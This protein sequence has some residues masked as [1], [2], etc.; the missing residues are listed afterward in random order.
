MF[1]HDKF[2]L[3]IFHCELPPIISYT[4]Q[5]L[6]NQN[7]GH[8][9]NA[10]RLIQY[11]GFQCVMY[12][13]DVLLIFKNIGLDRHLLTALYTNM[14]CLFVPKCIQPTHSILSFLIYSLL[15][16]Q[17]TSWHGTQDLQNT[18][19]HC[20]CIMHNRFQGDN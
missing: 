6:N 8:N 3:S 5:H 13:L 11:T 4:G 16:T 10:K 1:T 17:E 14:D 18:P 7:T 12:A 9:V 15:N 20:I 2:F 19:R